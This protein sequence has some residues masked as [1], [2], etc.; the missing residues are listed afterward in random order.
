MKTT[1]LV[2][3]LTLIFIIFFL[4][5]GCSPETTKQK[6]L[7]ASMGQEELEKEV[8]LEDN[9]TLEIK[10]LTAETGAT[11]CISQWRCISSTI[12]SFQESNC[13]FKAKEKCPISCDFETGNCKTIQCEEGFFCENPKTRAFRDKYCSWMLEEK[14]EFGCKDAVCLNETQAAE[15]TAGEKKQTGTGAAISK[16]D[17][18]EGVSWLNY[19]EKVN[20]SVGNATHTLSL[21]IMEAEKVKLMLDEF[22]SDW[23]HKSNTTK[24]LGGTII[25]SVIEINFQPYEGGLKQLGYKLNISN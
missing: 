17:P 6:N 2:S 20:I 7:E 4:L 1:F 12:R 13:T 3:Y 10:N 21:R 16:K 23:L 9:E 5:S 15:G 11:S 19:N 18:Y 24:F 14:C 25:I 22:T 8:A